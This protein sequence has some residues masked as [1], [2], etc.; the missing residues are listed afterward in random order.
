MERVVLEYL[1]DIFRT[2]SIVVDNMHATVL[3]L[4]PKVIGLM[5]EELDVEYRDEEIRATLFQMYPTKA[6]G[7][8]L[9]SFLTSRSLLKG[10]NFT[11]VCLILK[12]H[13]TKLVSDL[14]PITLCNVV[15]KICSK[16]ITNG[17]KKHPAE[18]I[19][20]FQSAFIL[21]RLITD[22]SLI[23]TEVSHYIDTVDTNIVMSLKIEMS[24][25]YDR[26][27]WC[28]LEAVLHRLG[29]AD[30]WVKLDM[31]CVMTVR[32]SLA[33]VDEC[34]TIQSVK[35]RQAWPVDQLYRYCPNLAT[36]QMLSF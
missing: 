25:A 4:E 13:S 20:P 15:Y 32:H 26:I 35:Q 11:H 18:I 16:V 21:G 7:L 34:L 23:A 6:P 29:F 27:E 2:A 3:L 14:R 24:K 33:T 28:F 1:F 22:N 5:N 8:D 9:R 12:V 30:Q 19:S 17:L 36:S 10:V 31:Q